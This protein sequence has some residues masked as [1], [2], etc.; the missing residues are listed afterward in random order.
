MLE[1]TRFV[2]EGLEGLQGLLAL[3]KTMESSHSHALIT[4]PEDVELGGVLPEWSFGDARCQRSWLGM[5][6]VVNVRRALELA[7]MRG[8]GS[9]VL[10]IDDAQIPQNSGRFRVRFAPGEPNAVD[11]TQE[12]PDVI[13]GIQDFSRLI[14]GGC[15]AQA[16]CWAGEA[17][18]S[19]GAGGAGIL[20]KAHV[21]QPILL[22]DGLLGKGQARAGGGGL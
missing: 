19:A 17:P 7:R 13:L 2:F 14:L 22:T 20:P 3:L 5:A 18:L 6:R 1:C 8:E 16:L 11:R 15:D 12:P 21:H 4:L 9:L 10:E